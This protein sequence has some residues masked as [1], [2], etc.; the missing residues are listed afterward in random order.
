MMEM[1][2]FQVSVT[3]FKK[4]CCLSSICCTVYTTL[5]H[6]LAIHAPLSICIHLFHG[7][8]HEKSRGELLKWSLAF[9]LYI[10]ELMNCM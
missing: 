7:A 10:G 1:H 4:K 3:L 5:D 8:G 2:A 6:I 9:S